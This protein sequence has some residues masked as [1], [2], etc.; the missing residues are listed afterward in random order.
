M[1]TYVIKKIILIYLWF[2]KL[3]VTWATK[4]T[5]SFI[6]TLIAGLLT[7]LSLKHCKFGLFIKCEDYTYNNAF[8][9]DSKCKVIQIKIKEN[10]ME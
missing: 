7:L 1:I 9:K 8:H 5:K 10:T 6:I 3:I 2:L 4:Y